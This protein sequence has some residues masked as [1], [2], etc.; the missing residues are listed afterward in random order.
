MSD[1]QAIPDEILSALAHDLRTPISVIVGYAELIEKRSA[2]AKTREAACL[3][4]EAADRLRSAVDALL[5][6]ARAQ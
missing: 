1:G 6:D 3:I 5:R 2:E 4:L